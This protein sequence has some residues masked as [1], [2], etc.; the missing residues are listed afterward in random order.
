[1]LSLTQ[2]SFG[3][4]KQIPFIS[5]FNKCTIMHYL[6]QILDDKILVVPST[7]FC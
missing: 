1:M 2:I 3:K 4:W 6:F 7:D 5:M